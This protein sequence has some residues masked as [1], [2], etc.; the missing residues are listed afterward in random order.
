MKTNFYHFSEYI[1][2]SQQASPGS[3]T[4]TDTLVTASPDIL[5]GCQT[6]LTPIYTDDGHILMASPN[7]YMNHQY[8][9]P[10][11]SLLYGQ[12]K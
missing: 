1:T 7:I 10:K 3:N 9:E 2:V 6:A 5:Q 8:I 11:D 4:Y 12:K